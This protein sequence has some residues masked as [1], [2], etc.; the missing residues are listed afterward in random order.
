[1]IDQKI[2]N[3]KEEMK[4]M[5]NLGTARKHYDKAR[6]YWIK[7][8]P[9]LS[10]NGLLSKTIMSKDN[11]RYKEPKDEKMGSMMIQRIPQGKTLEDVIVEEVLNCKTIDNYEYA[12]K[13][14]MCVV[15]YN[16]GFG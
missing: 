14:L 10:V 12:A 4:T 8:F 16:M 5:N 15:I 9:G 1:M 3:I 11:P 7:H 2:Q 13:M 6:L